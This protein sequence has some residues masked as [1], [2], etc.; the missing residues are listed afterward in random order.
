[1]R[2]INHKRLK[3]KGLLIILF[4]N[5][6]SIADAKPIK[7]C[8]PYSNF[9]GRS[10]QNI[11]VQQAQ[12][13]ERNIHDKLSKSLSG[14]LF[15]ALRE[16][17][18]S[19]PLQ[20]LTNG[21]GIAFA[22][23]ERFSGWP[24]LSD[25]SAIQYLTIHIPDG[26]FKNREFDLSKHDKALVVLTE[27]SSSFRN[28]CFGYAKKGTL[29]LMVSNGDNSVLLNKMSRPIFDTI[30]EDT[31][32]MDID[33]E[34]TTKMTNEAWPSPEVCGTC[35]LQGHFIFLKSSLTEFNRQ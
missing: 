32:L 25:T 30:G 23:R 11:W 29:K 8:F 26:P 1:M 13:K 14:T 27:G 7:Q 21:D 10:I 20:E 19:V 5:V 33:I 24:G 16:N 6:L 31:I 15:S 12:L 4:V 28:F 18:I 34:V 3:F 22:F 17:N 2:L 35:V 9:P